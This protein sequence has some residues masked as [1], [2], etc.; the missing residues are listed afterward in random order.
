MAD[1]A[2][3][4]DTD[5]PGPAGEVDTQDPGTPDGP[6]EGSPIHPPRAV[7]AA[8]IGAAAI[9]L[10]AGLFAGGLYVGTRTD[11][12]PR[13]D[14]PVQARRDF[15]FQVIG[16]Q[17]PNQGGKT[18]NLFFH[19]RYTAGIAERDIPNYLKMR[20][21]AVNYLATADLS[22]NPYWETL[23]TRMC[24]QLKDSYPL[25]GISC[26]LQVLGSGVPGPYEPGYRASVETIGDIEP[27]SIPGPLTVR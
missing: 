18:I 17:A 20:D 24:A 23:N 22:R 16:L 26:E 8:L 27:L 13:A 14:A 10:G 4:Q 19:Y 7:R 12:D 21:D 25:S 9:L 15:M 1:S 2:S 11:P 6:R 5:T 3:P